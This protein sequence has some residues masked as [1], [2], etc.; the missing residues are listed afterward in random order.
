MAGLVAMRPQTSALGESGELSVVEV[1]PL[2]AN[3]GVVAF[4][5]RNNTP[6]A[7]ADIDWT[8]VVRG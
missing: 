8:A 2:E 4:A 1:G 3:A 6:D 7:L 5:F